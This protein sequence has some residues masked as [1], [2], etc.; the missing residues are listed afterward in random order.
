VR[1]VFEWSAGGA[2]AAREEWSLEESGTARTLKAAGRDLV[3]REITWNLEARIAPPAEIHAL[4]LQ[5][6]PPARPSEVTT[7][8]FRCFGGRAYGTTIPPGGVPE[9]FESA[10]PA[11][12]T[13]RAFSAAME[14]LAAVG[15]DL[16]VG[17]G[18]RLLVVELD[19][20]DLRPR[21]ADA[22][23]L[24]RSRQRIT[25]QAGEAACTAYEFR[26]ADSPGRWVQRLVATKAGVVV[27]GERAD[28]TSPWV[29]A[30]VSFKP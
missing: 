10:F 9:K 8:A 12:S 29:G 5:V 2:L 3:D 25:T 18:R 28:R 17:H 21:V 4:D 15:G 14:G 19:T 23:F 11:G 7:T 24:A 16:K 22:I 6:R 26:W 27:K 13:F 20:H 30:L 1:G